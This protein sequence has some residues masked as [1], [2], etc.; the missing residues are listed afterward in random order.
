MALQL[1]VSTVSRGGAALPASWTTTLAGGRGPWRVDRGAWMETF[2][3]TGRTVEQQWHFASRPRGRGSLVVAL[4]VSSPAMASTAQGLHFRV[5]ERFVRYGHGTWVDARGVRTAVPAQFVDGAIHLEV[6]EAVLESSAFP[7]VLDP[8]IGAESAIDLPVFGPAP[9][10]RHMPAVGTDGVNDLVVWVDS[11]S[12][13]EELWA[14]RVSPLGAVLDPQGIRIAAAHVVEHIAVGSNGSMFLVAWSS[15]GVQLQAV[16]ID[17]AGHVLDSTPLEILGGS[18]RSPRVASDGVDFL[19]VWDDLRTPTGIYAGRVTSG[20]LLLD[21]AGIPLGSGADPD[22]AWNGNEY[23]VVWNGWDIRAVRM[24]RSGVVLGTGSVVLSTSDSL[25]HPRVASNGL[26]ALVVWRTF[27]G[28]IAGSRFSSTGQVLDPTPISI[29]ALPSDEVRANV[30]WDGTD[31]LV[32]WSADYT[33]PTSAL[34]AARVSSAGAVLDTPPLGVVARGACEPYFIP[35]FSETDLTCNGNHC[36]SAF[37]GDC[38]P[39]AESIFGVRL[40][41]N[42][43]VDVPPVRLS[44]TANSE[45][46]AAAASN[47]TESLVV[48]EDSRGADSDVYGVRVQPSGAVDDAPAFA[49]ASGPGNQQRPRVASNGSTWLVTWQ[50]DVDGGARAARVAATGAVLDPAGLAVSS[51]AALA[52][53]VA[54][55]GADYLVA[56][57]TPAGAVAARRLDADGGL[58]DVADVL[59]ATDAGGL[60]TPV[61]VAASATEW[62]VAWTAGGPQVRA[63]RVSSAGVALEPGG[64][65]V[66]AGFLPSI[67]SD[68]TDFLVARFRDAGTGLEWTGSRFPSTSPSDVV[69]ASHVADAGAA[70]LT[71][72]GGSYLAAWTVLPL[73][74]YAVRAGRVSTTGVAVDGPSGFPLG[75]PSGV[76][77]G[78]ALA[79][80]DTRCLLASTRFDDTLHVPRVVTRPLVANTA[81]VVASRSVTTPEDV[82]ATWVLSGF[83]ADSDALSFRITRAPVHGRLVDAAPAVVRYEPDADFHGTDDFAFV[84]SDRLVDSAPAEVSITVTPVNDAPVP[85]P[86]AATTDEDTPVSI[87]LRA[88]DVDGDALS[89]SIT[90][91]PRHG[92]LSGTPPEVTY[93]PAPDF[94][95][96]DDFEWVASDGV[97]DSAVA[98]VALTVMP[99]NDAPV[100]ENQA[101]ETLQAKALTVRLEATDV[102]G[103][104]LTYDV[105][106]APAH[107]TLSGTAPTLRYVPATDFVGLDSVGFR[108]SDGQEWSTTAEVR[109]TVNAAPDAGV[110]DG[111][112]ASAPSGG[113]GCMTGGEIAPWLLAVML[114][115]RRR[116]RVL[117]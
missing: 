57:R 2:E 69:L 105:V 97:T 21:P 53:D 65:A 19:V 7:A 106:A 98:Q 23:V 82:P 107:G 9:R 72:A 79:C 77:P 78:P 67:A 94:N 63:G 25:A 38:W 81:P 15:G 84:A 42:T 44:T 13:P 104:A 29:S 96:A 70:A 117:R 1:G 49:I 45:V 22:V 6:P 18:P 115:A 100:A 95:G 39:D 24:T 47:G 109:I 74:Q 114:A 93:Q 34:L 40:V 26:D 110:A 46:R 11:R 88:T 54:A 85:A 89:F 58:L 71:F 83:D 103:D 37:Y 102:D 99:V 17:D 14:T 20:G 62:A 28:D 73:G 92:T 76:A 113:C 27:Q 68:G 50:D 32:V 111:P 87:T 116:R 30:G 52:P 75:V 108:A 55:R 59:L 60:T 90:A 12:G 80:V 35:Y 101:L 31:Y 16:R 48:W 4:P 61:A 33:N 8:Q 56:W 86:L 66:G 3:R 64:V 112:G 91:P 10:G 5:G 41:G 51:G 43:V 36:L